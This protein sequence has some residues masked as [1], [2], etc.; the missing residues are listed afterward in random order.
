MTFGEV[1][2]PMAR[3]FLLAAA[4]PASAVAPEVKRV[5][6]HGVPEPA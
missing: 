2:I 4:D 6:S 5:L 3:R 1:V